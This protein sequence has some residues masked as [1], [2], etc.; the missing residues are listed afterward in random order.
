MKVK[1]AIIMVISIL[2][3][4]V[5]CFGQDDLWERAYEFGLY[6]KYG[7]PFKNLGLGVSMND[8]INFE[9]FKSDINIEIWQQDIYGN[10]ISAKIKNQW[11]ITENLGLN[12]NIGYKTEGYLLGKQLDSGLNLGAGICIYRP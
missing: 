10:G 11:K 6:L 8:A 4:T 3:I 7:R 12:F 2:I 9:N 1:K 5:N